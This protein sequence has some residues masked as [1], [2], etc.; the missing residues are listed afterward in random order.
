MRTLLILLLVLS[1]NIFALHA[2]TPVDFTLKSATDDKTFQLSSAKGEMVALHFLL[3]TECPVCLKHTRSY[4][5][6][7]PAMLPGV[8]QIF[9][10]PDT[11]AEIKT[12]S[13]SVAS[14]NSLAVT[15]Y[16][17]PE[18]QLA[19]QFAI[20][21]GYQFHGQTVHYPALVLLDKNGKELFRYIGKNNSDR[22]SVEQL[23]AKIES[24][25]NP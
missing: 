22:M 20:P 19:K 6:D 8:R 5:K 17:D 16:R 4:I 11:D 15:I 25:K 2:A 24:L 14:T 10:K 12:W 21:D 13:A 9:I 1:H 18:A 7:A 23:K 3:K